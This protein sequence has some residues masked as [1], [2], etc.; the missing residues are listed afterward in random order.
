M[1]N[2]QVLKICNLKFDQEIYPRIKTSWLTAYQYAQS[3][4]AGSVFPPINVGKLNEEL[5]VID[6]WHRVEAKKIL[7]EEYI[8]AIIKDYKDKKEMFVEAINLNISHGRPL[9]IQE[10]VRLVKKLEDL[11]FTIEKISEITRIPID[12]IEM[13]KVRTVIA[14]N[15]KPIFVKSIVAK[16]VESIEE[17]TEVDMDKFSARTIIS[18]LTQLIELLEDD[19]YP[20]Q[21]KEV[22]ELTIRLYT[23]L[24]DKLQIKSKINEAR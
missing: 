18:L 24:Q 20:L 11:N 15:G 14:P 7:G 16:S 3:M 8:E 21:N 23:L 13:F 6:G 5:Y 17:A 19:I 1:K 4:R 12:K 2:L 22:K 9:S 10:K